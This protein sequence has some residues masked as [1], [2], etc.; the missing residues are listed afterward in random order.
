MKKRDPKETVEFSFMVKTGWR[1]VAEGYEPQHETRGT[2]TLKLFK[3][4]WRLMK[5]KNH[6]LYGVLTFE[7]GEKWIWQPEIVNK[8]GRRQ[9]GWQLALKS[10][11]ERR[12]AK[13][14]KQLTLWTKFIFNTVGLD[15]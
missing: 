15:I 9:G 5:N 6:L 3:S 10:D 14:E 12:K 8:Y 4:W 13:E 11:S 7:D 2:K 1:E